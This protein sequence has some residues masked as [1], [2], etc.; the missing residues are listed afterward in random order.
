MSF[1]KLNILKHKSWNVWNRDN[2]EKV[3]KDERL[4]REDE[5]KKRKRAEEGESEM[6]VRKLRELKSAAS[7]SSSEI[8][9]ISNRFHKAGEGESEGTSSTA[10]VAAS[11]TALVATSE[12]TKPKFLNLFE[13]VEG[14]ID[15]AVGNDTATSGGKNKDTEVATLVVRD[16]SAALRQELTQVCGCQAEKKKE[17]DKHERQWGMVGLGQDSFTGSFPASFITIRCAVSGADVGCAARRRQRCRQ[18]MVLP[19][20]PAPL[21]LF[22]LRSSLPLPPLLPSASYISH[23]A[24]NFHSDPPTLSSHP[25]PLIL[26]SLLPPSSSSRAAPARAGTL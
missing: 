2:I 5:E 11:S 10:V 20:L 4:H 18:A 8:T 3:L 13:G 14:V 6:R 21:P 23:L 26:P 7:A 1:G 16:A 9:A 17:K 24:S 25:P 12:E 19:L 15:G 22:L